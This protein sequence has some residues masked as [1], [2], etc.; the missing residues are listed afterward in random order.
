MPTAE[1]T[2]DSQKCGLSCFLSF[3]YFCSH[4]SENANA[5]A[6]P[7]FLVSNTQK[8]LIFQW[9]Q[10]IV[11]TVYCFDVTSKWNSFEITRN[12]FASNRTRVRIP[13]AAPRRE[14]TPDGVSSFLFCCVPPPPQ[15]VSCQQRRGVKE[16]AGEDNERKIALHLV[17]RRDK[18]LD[19]KVANEITSGDQREMAERFARFFPAAEEK[20]N[21]QRNKK[22]Q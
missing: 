18:A 17:A 21:T 3:V 13:P 19:E 20:G 6:I 2:N 7:V 9:V 12:Q 16:R 5:P 4:F 22:C 1:K 11:T 8:V 15:E 10:G 14:E